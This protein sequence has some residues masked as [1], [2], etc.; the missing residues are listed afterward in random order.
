M[1]ITELVAEFEEDP[2]M[3]RQMES[4]RVQLA[5]LKA[6][7]GEEGFRDW[8]LSNFINVEDLKK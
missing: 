1:T 7:L 3:K 2:V 6:E 5:T 8:L 4:A